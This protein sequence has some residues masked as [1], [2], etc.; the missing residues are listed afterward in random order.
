MTMPKKMMS[1]IMDTTATMLTNND[2]DDDSH[3][4]DDDGDDDDDDDDDDDSSYDQCHPGLVAQA[5]I[6]GV[7]TTHSQGLISLGFHITN[8]WQTYLLSL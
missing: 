2:E 4:D 3:D 8:T 5:R 1:V 7:E 6:C